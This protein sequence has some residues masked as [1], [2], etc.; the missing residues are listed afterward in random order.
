MAS[1]T[2]DFRKHFAA[3]SSGDSRSCS[4]EDWIDA[5]TN[6]TSQDA[7]ASDIDASSASTPNTDVLLDFEGA[8]SCK[9]IDPKYYAEDCPERQFW[10]EQ[11]GADQESGRGE[12]AARP[13]SA[14]DGSLTSEGLADFIIDSTGAG[15]STK[16]VISGDLMSFD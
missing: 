3:F 6:S 16:E 9:V 2:V 4:Y 15:G 5:L 13:Q 11:V 14:N 8:V 7:A 1:S 10:N 12:V